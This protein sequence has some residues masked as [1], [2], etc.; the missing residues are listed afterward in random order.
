MPIILKSQLDTILLQQNARWQSKESWI[1]SIPDAQRLNLLGVSVDFVQLAALNASLP[2][3]GAVVPPLAGLPTSTDW[4]NRGGQNFISPVKNQGGCGSCVSF[5]TCALVEAMAA[6]EHSV[7]FLDLSEAELHFCSVHG[8]NCGGW[9]PTNALD[10][11][12]A[13]GVVDEGS[14]PYNSAFSGANPHCVVVPNR[15]AKATKIGSWTQLTSMNDRKNWLANIGPLSAVFHV[16]DDFFSYHTGVYHHTTGGEAGYHCVEV[17]GYSDIEQC[18]ICKNSW[19]DS[20]GDHGF[21]KI[22]YGQCGIDDTS[23]DKGSNGQLLRFPMWGCRQVQLPPPPAPKIS[24]IASTINSDGR[25]EVFATELANNAVWNDW[26]VNPHAGPWAG[27]HPMGGM[28]KALAPICNSDGRLELLGIGMDDALWTNWQTH[29]HAGPWSGWNSL[30]GKVKAISAACN[31]DGRL[32]VFGIGMDDAAWDIWQTHPHAGPWSAWKSSPLAW[33]MP[34][35]PSGKPTP[36]PVPGP[37]GPPSAASSKPS[38]P[39]SIPTAALKPSASAWTMPS[40]TLGKLTPTPAPGPAGTP[41]A[42][43]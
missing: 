16:Y 27:M 20:W 38:T 34:S 37:P 22:A 43:R 42:V 6:V 25:L 8:P 10:E 12:K 31:S 4:R 14:F 29:P 32:E 21:F 30:G 2:S 35:G 3:A 19:A 15:A 13:K 9:W 41:S 40:G 23:P 26:Q 39:R 24:R 28:V 11:V 18:W 1:T 5:C 33:T 7:R 17:I 36:T